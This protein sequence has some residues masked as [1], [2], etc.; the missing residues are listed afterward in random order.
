MTTNLTVE[1][2]L[3]G[4]SRGRM[5]TVG[6]MQVIPILGDD[7]DAFDPPDFTVGTQDYGSV[8]LRNDGD[9]PTIVPTGAGWVVRAAAQDHAV[10]SGALMPAKS[11]RTIDTAMC[12]QQTQGGLISKSKHKML[13]LP[14]ALRSPALAKRKERGYDKLWASIS[15]F[16]ESVGAS[17]RYGGGHLEYFLQKYQRELDEFVAEF[18]LV[19][20][21]IGAIVLI[22]GKVVG[23]ERA[24]SQAFWEAVWEP[25]IRV[26]Y[27]SLAIKASQGTTTPPS[28]RVALTAEAISTLGEIAL[29]LRDARSREEGV[30]DTLVADVGSKKLKAAEADERMGDHYLTT[31]A[32][33]ALAGQVVTEGDGP[34]KIRYA[35]ICAARG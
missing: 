6:Q 31:V 19:P 27:G 34:E 18:E 25:L 35:S 3:A 20:D 11:S 12:I 14:V 22:N 24:P 13:V 28:T 15:E 1:Q 5:Q 33:R 32:S 21:Q 4:T 2:I 26:C 30:V 17:D 7:D 16:N 29:A 9:R 10:G 8:H 23:I